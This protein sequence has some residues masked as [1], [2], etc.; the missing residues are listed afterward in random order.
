MNIAQDADMALNT[1]ILLQLLLKDNNN[2][3]KAKDLLTTSF[4]TVV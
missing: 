1:Y 4:C 2:L 3:L